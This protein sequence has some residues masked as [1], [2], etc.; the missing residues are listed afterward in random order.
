MK[1]SHSEFSS[2]TANETQSAVISEKQHENKKSNNSKKISDEKKKVWS[3]WAK[4]ISAGIIGSVLTLSVI[5]FTNYSDLFDS[6]TSSQSSAQSHSGTSREEANSSGSVKVEATVVSNSTIADMV[7]EAA[8]AIVGVVNVQNQTSNYYSPFEQ[9]QA[10]D[11]SVESGSGSGVIFKKDSDYAYIVTNYHVIEGADE[12]EVSLDSG[13]RAKAQ[14]VGGDA[15][16]DLAVLKIESSYVTSVLSFG[17]S[18]TLRA[19]EDVIAIGNPLGL[20]L[21][22]TVTQGIVS[23]VDRTVSVTTSAGDWDLNVIQT[24]AAINPGNSGGALLN[25]AGQVVGINSL[26][27]SEDG[28]EG[29][30]FAIPSNDLV[31]IINEILEKGSVQRVYLGVGLM[32][33]SEVPIMYLERLNIPVEEGVIITSVES[34]SA[35]DDAGLEV[36][37]VIVKIDDQSVADSTD[38][39]KYLYSNLEVGDQVTIEFY[40]GGELKTTTVTLESN[41]AVTTN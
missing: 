35:A 26:K 20:D 34:G 37:D 13:D 6:A 4:T 22:R 15:L 31:P 41:N 1:Q 12:I 19:G 29:L 9:P 17:D 16:S 28:V 11:E 39:R 24:D 2:E 36:Q 3:S 10:T 8:P 25:T 32:S 40:R 38:L 5:P 14:L 21:S 7:E 33:L 23:A 18:S 27:I 30:G